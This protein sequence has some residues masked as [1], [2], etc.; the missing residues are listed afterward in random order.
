MRQSGFSEEA[1][2]GIPK[3]HAAT[4]GC[5]DERRVASRN[6]QWFGQGV[7]NRCQMA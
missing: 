7:L 4:G 5:V 6:A 2:I 3:E 1:I